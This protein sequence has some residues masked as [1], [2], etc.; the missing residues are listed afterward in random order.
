MTTNELFDLAEEAW[1]KHVQ[2]PKVITALILLDCPEYIFYLKLSWK[3]SW[4]QKQKL[5][6]KFLE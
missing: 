1:Q 3:M 6:I 5:E 4:L 2:S